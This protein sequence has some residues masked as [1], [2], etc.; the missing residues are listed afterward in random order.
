M[1]LL[2]GKGGQVSTMEKRAQYRSK[3][4]GSRKAMARETITKKAM[5]K[6]LKGMS[7]LMSSSLTRQDAI[8]VGMPSSIVALAL[9][10]SIMHQHGRPL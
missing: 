2:D 8:E 9:V 4:V 7:S 1:Y 6:A 5:I 3:N 10:V